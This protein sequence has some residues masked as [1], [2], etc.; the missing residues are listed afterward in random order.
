MENVHKELL[1]NITESILEVPGE[2]TIDDKVFTLIR[3]A[4]QE[5]SID[6]PQSFERNIINQIRVAAETDLMPILEKFGLEQAG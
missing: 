4:W 2:K 5:F 3:T 1:Q 6:A